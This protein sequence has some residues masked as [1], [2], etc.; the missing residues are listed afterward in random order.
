MFRSKF[1]R[2]LVW[3]CFFCLHFIEKDALGTNKSFVKLHACWALIHIIFVFFFFILESGGVRLIFLLHSSTMFFMWR[4]LFFSFHMFKTCSIQLSVLMGLVNFHQFNVCIKY[5]SQSTNIVASLFVRWLLSC[6]GCDEMDPFGFLSR[7]FDSTFVCLLLP[8]CISCYQA[9]EKLHVCHSLWNVA[10]IP[11]WTTKTTKDDRNL[12]S[13]HS[14]FY[15]ENF[16][17]ELLS[18]RRFVTWSSN[19]E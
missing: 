13:F 3:V 16:R 10:R 1:C 9:I 17:G 5:S 14:L 19:K 6:V 15:V 18:W 4:T 8:N 11:T 12:M 7:T 2:F